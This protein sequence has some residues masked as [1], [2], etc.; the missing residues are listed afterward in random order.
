MRS[1]TAATASICGSGPASPRWSEAAGS[2]RSS[3]PT[4]RASPADAVVVGL[5]SLPNT[6]W[7]AAG[8][9]GLDPGLACDA[10]LT[11]VGDA[12]VLAAGDIASWPHPLA[13]GGAIRIEHWTVAAEHGQLAGR[14]ALLAPAER[15]PYDAPPYFWSDQYDQ[16]IQSLGMPGRAERLELLESTPDGARRLY[17][18][19]RDGR[20]VGIVAINAARRLGTYR[21]ALG[22]PPSS[23][24]LRVRVA[25]DPGA[26]GAAPRA[27]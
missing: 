10:T 26:L 14:N 6:E 5:G 21:L 24:D 27:A 13:G 22:D 20:L 7:L 25:G 9:L 3:S 18:G 17:A 12:D 8:G 16:K 15:S 23:A 1:S 2:R 11:A 4:A 19:E